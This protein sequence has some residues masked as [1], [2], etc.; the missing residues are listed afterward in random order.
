MRARDSKRLVID[1]DVVQASGKEEATK[2]R[3]VHCRNFLKEVRTQNHR[4]VMTRK[5]SDEWRR[6]LSHFAR[7]WMVSMYARR[8][9]D[10]IN[11]PE[12]ETLKNKVASTANKV[13]EVEAVEKDFHLL[14]AALA[15]DRTVI[16]LDETIR[17]LFA[18]ASQQVGEI[19]D[20]I[21]VNPERTEEK[22]IV[23]LQ[24][25]APPEACRRLSA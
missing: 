23:W 5:I 13:K 11:P 12:D 19:R 17:E 9:I 14:Q 21:W 4:V 18:Q 10:Y 7:G 6:H 25:G 3:P 1:T 24:N 15:T 8:K 22:P 20:I 2:P 16:S